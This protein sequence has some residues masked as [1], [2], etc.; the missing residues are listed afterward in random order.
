MDIF[1]SGVFPPRETGLWLSVCLCPE[2]WQHGELS[3]LTFF[4][5]PPTIENNVQSSQ[6][7]R[8]PMSCMR[9]EDPSLQASWCNKIY[10]ASV[11]G[12]VS[13]GDLDW[14]HLYFWVEWLCEVWL[15][16]VNSWYLMRF[17]FSMKW[18]Q[19]EFLIWAW[20]MKKR[21]IL[22]VLTEGQNCL[23]SLSAS[24]RAFETPKCR[25]GLLLQFLPPSRLHLLG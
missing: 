7:M 9:R 23:C 17:F 3:V 14:G 10:K 13:C 12:T 16:E 2:G 4:F 6:P 22:S 24:F 1:S 21:E 20:K 18:D 19:N 5:F 11:W 25:A 8:Q 15:C